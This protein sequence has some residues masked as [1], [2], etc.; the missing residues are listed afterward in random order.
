VRPIELDHIHVNDKVA[1]VAVVGDNMRGTTG[2]AGRVFG[3]LG[4]ES[5][6]IIAIAQGSSENNISF[7]VDEHAVQR[8]VSC[9]HNEFHLEKGIRASA[10]QSVPVGAAVAP[11]APAVPV[12]A[13]ER[14]APQR[15]AK[16]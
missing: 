16:R 13:A 6:N 12:V 5:V 10:P 8:A 2:V 4:R 3:R 11:S 9:I 15:E 7:L 14:G 1:I